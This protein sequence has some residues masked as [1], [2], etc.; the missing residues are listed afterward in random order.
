THLYQS[1]LALE[2]AAKAYQLRDKVT[3]REKL[4]ISA[5]YFMSRKELEKEAQTYE[6]WT[7]MYPRDWVPHV[8]LSANYMTMGQYDKALREG[9]EA[10]RLAPDD[11]VNYSNLGFTYMLLNRLDEAK[12]TLDGAFGHRLD[13]RELRWSIYQVAFLRGDSTQMEQQLAWATGK[14]G[15]EDTFLFAQ[16]NSELY[17]GHVKKARELSQRAVDS[18][19]RADS[20]ERAALWRANAARWEAE[21]GNRASAKRDSV[22]A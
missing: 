3:E 19:L 18:S 5:S 21:L 20:K 22:A 13:G 17:H 10:L 15:V 16:S 7:A 9:Q 2:S 6:L 11:V 4:R 1:S 14:P 8:N 12:A